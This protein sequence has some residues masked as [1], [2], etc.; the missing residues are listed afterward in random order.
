MKLISCYRDDTGL[1]RARTADK[2]QALA[3]FLETDIQEDT[4]L[5]AELLKQIKL[6]KKGKKKRYQSSGNAHTVTL[7]PKT[8]TLESLYDDEAPRYRLKL[9]H[10]QDVLTRWTDNI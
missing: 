4:A 9:S 1:L 6:L 5:V 7:T 2:D 3:V 8:A 10:F